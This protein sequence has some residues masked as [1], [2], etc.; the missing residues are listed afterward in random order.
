[1]TD[2]PSI[3][4]TARTALLLLALVCCTWSPSNAGINIFPPFVFV[5]SPNR[6]VS[7]NVTNNSL[8]DTEVWIDFRFGYPASDDTGG[9]YMKFMDSVEVSEPTA[10]SW[11]RVFPQRFVLGPQET[12][13][14]RVIITPPPGQAPGE[15]W[16]RVIFHS[17]DKKEP[18]QKPGQTG[19]RTGFKLMT[20]LDIPIHYRNGRVSTGVTLLDARASVESGFIKVLSDLQRSGNASFWGT[21]SMKLRDQDGK[22]V[23]KKD[24]NVV[25]YEGLRF[26]SRLNI[27]QVKSGSYTL[28]VE[29]ST[30][31]PDLKPDVVLTAPPV[32]KS[33][34]VIIP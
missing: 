16:A 22:I 15:Y 24:N 33:F 17:I 30:R 3:R 9:I 2:T 26:L 8:T 7:L 29:F 34:S 27:A 10:V 12:Q 4:V 11:L 5:G 25:V 19:T 20:N 13:T 6:A 32:S 31:R 23:A 21:C 1:L 14:V 28:D 18:E